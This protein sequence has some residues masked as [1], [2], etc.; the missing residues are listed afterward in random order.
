MSAKIIDG[1]AIAREI[2]QELIPRIEALRSQGITPGLAAILVGENPASKIYVSMK[3]KA[4]QEIGIFTL[5]RQLPERI[6]Q[7]DLLREIDSLN[8]DRRIHGILIQLP[9]PGH[10]DTPSVLEAVS[11]QKDVDGFHPVNMGRLLLGQE[12]FIPCTPAGVLELLRRSGHSPEGKHVVI[13]GRSNIV[14]KPLANLLLQKAPGRN[15]TVTICHTGTADLA[16]FTCQA[17]ILIVA[18]GRPRVVTGA[19][20]KEGAVVIDVGVN[21]IPDPHSQ[22]GYHIVGDV[23]FDSVRQVAGAITPVPGGV[24]P[25]TIAMLLRNTVQAAEREARS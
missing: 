4:C 20:V 18:A 2:K 11:P 10:L 9:L 22:K 21:R 5:T 16:S 17:D 7:Q 14:G 6:D 3:E 15:A 12:A 13:V 1:R 19:M 24:G 23:D 25:M 8:R